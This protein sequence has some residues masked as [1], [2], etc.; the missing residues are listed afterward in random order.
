MNRHTASVARYG[1]TF[2]TGAM[3]TA[4][5]AF[6]AMRPEHTADDLELVAAHGCLDATPVL[7]C[8]SSLAG[9]T[10][11]IGYASY[12]HREAA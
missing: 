5:L 7:P 4:A 1:A 2:S 10:P 11:S 3:L 8:G 6:S 9:E 12:A